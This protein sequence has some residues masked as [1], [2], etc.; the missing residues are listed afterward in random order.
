M[1]AEKTIF[2]LFFKDLKKDW[3]ATRFT[4]HT[5]ATLYCLTLLHHIKQ[6]SYDRHHRY[7]QSI[8][9]LPI[10]HR[11]NL[12]HLGLYNTFLGSFCC[13]FYQ[14]LNLNTCK[15]A[16]F[17]IMGQFLAYGDSTLLVDLYLESQKSPRIPQ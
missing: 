17:N 11:I 5:H 3:M 8:T 13:K 15:M 2:C 4:K 9:W 1:K 10:H 6:T 12:I 7:L 14:G 16:R